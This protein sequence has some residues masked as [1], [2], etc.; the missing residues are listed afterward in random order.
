M[1]AKI[2]ANVLVVLL[3]GYSVFSLQGEKFGVNRLTRIGMFAA[4]T[5]VLYMIKLV[6]FP[7]GGGCSLLSVLPIMILAVIAGKSEA[8][9]CGIVVALLKLIIAPPYFLMQIPLDYFGAMMALSLTPIF[10]VDSKIKLFTGAL[11][12]SG[13]SIF[14]SILSGVIFFGMYAPEGMNTWWYAIVYN[15][16]GYGVEVVLSCVV[17]VMLPLGFFNREVR[18]GRAA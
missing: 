18:L 15:G 9:F 2:F 10:G 3:G 12:A 13:L 8:M 14:F 7:Q 6:P 5:I 17:L 1:L 11:F 4:L 16:T